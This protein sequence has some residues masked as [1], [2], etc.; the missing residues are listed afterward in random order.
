MLLLVT[1]STYPIVTVIDVTGWWFDV[2]TH[3]FIIT[4]FFA[5]D[6]GELGDAEI[7]LMENMV[8][9]LYSLYSLILFGLLT[10][11]CS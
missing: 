10:Y 6:A 1:T 8:G 2:F 4:H 3:F 5:V 7:Q 11:T 9:Y